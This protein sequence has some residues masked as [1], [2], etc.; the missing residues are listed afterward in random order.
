MSEI[1]ITT[2]VKREKGYIYFVNYDEQGN[3]Q[4]SRAKSGRRKKDKPS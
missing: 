1:I 4:V 3:I 2:E